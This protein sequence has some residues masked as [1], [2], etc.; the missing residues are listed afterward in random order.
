MCNA[1]KLIDGIDKL[2]NKKNMNQLISR[3]SGINFT[4]KVHAFKINEY[5]ACHIVY[6]WL[7]LQSSAIKYFDVATNWKISVGYIWNH[8]LG[9]KQ[10]QMKFSKTEIQIKECALLLN[11]IN[12]ERK[13]K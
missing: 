9:K 5:D 3:I 8:D 11:K 4:W 1:A 10:M 13:I 2:L 7:D 6:W 12:W